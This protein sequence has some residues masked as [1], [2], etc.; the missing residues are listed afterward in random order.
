MTNYNT[1][2]DKNLNWGEKKGGGGQQERMH[3]F[4]LNKKMSCQ[5]KALDGNID[6]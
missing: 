5:M 2:R 1:I 4:L 3:F 6:E